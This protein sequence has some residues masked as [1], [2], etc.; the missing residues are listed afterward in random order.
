VLFLDCD[1]TL[2]ENNIYF[3]RAIDA[4]LDEVEHADLSREAAR[5][6]FNDIE[7]A[8]TVA[9]GYGSLVFSRSLRDSYAR[10]FPGEVS[11]A[12]LRRIEALGTAILDQELE[13]IP[14]VETTLAELARRH[15]LTMLTKGQRDEQRLKVERSGLETY[16]HHVEIVAEKNVAT[17][18]AVLETLGVA[19]E[20]AWMVGN[21]PKSDINPALAA[22]MG[23]VFIPHD[24]TWIL[25]HEEVDDGGDRLLRLDRLVDLLRYF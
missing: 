3:E 19:P 8:N 1:D 16:V 25:E 15:T 17:Y 24:H 9:H 4:F 18:R 7:R 11:E 5:A 21:S 6:V 13:L 10:L 2:W 14:H 22:G 23:A 20:R 12:E